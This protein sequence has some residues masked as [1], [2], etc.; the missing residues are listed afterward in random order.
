MP[1]MNVT[2]SAAVSSG[3]TVRSC[4]T[5]PTWRRTATGSAVTSSPATRAVPDVGRSSVRRMRIVVV[6]PAP[7]GPSSPKI[8]LLP[9]SKLAPSSALVEPKSLV[10]SL[11]WT[12]G[13]ALELMVVLID[14]R[15]QPVG[16]VNGERAPERLVHDLRGRLVPRAA[17]TLDDILE[18]LV[19]LEPE[20]SRGD[21][22]VVRDVVQRQPAGAAGQLGPHRRRPPP[23]LAAHEVQRQAE[24][25]VELPRLVHVP[26]V[27]DRHRLHA[28]SPFS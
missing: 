27:P 19:R 15:Q 18:R 6:L 14:L 8:S 20:R 9:T 10:R 16:V 26:H 23:R 22:H 28:S 21:R 24:R 12:A 25:L 3:S 2:F 5:Q 13:S 1:A 17:E 7:F 11:T 4:G